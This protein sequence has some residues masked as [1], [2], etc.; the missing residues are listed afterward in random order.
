MKN[1]YNL[2]FIAFFQFIFSQNSYHDTKGNIEV[3]SGGQLQFTLPI[4][5]PKGVKN[6]SRS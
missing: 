1:F 6:V 4:E 3:N 2:F 5:L